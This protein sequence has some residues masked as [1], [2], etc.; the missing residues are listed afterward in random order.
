M[1]RII[2]GRLKRTLVLMYLVLILFFAFT[3]PQNLPIALI[4]AP[5]LWAF[6]CLSMT[7]YLVLQWFGGEKEGAHKRSLLLSTTFSGVLCLVLLLRSINQLNSRDLLLAT[8]FFI[9]ASIYISKFKLPKRPA[10]LN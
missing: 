4:V 6:A 8:V 7:F 2:T 5:I 3:N 1:K 10:E 9:V